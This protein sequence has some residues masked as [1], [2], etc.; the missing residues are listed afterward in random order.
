MD[1]YQILKEY[2]GYDDF[3]QG[4]LKAIDS[5][6]SGTDTVAIMPTGGGKSICFQVPAMMFRGIT[7]VISP[8]ISLMNDQ[9]RA[10]SQCG[11]PAAYINTSLDE[12]VI[13]E[14]I[15]RT[16]AGRYKILYVAPERLLTSG[17]RSLCNTVEVSFVAIDEAHC[18]SQWGQD[19]RPSYLDI[20]EFIASLDKRPV[21]AAFTATATK[22]V[23]QDICSLL[24][25]RSPE[26]IATGFDREN[27][28][29]EV[30]KVKDKL[31]ALKRYLDL[32]SGSSGIVYCSTRKNVD[33]LYY[34]LK[35]ENIPV[36]R[37]HAGLSKNER[38]NNQDSFIQDE[39]P[40]IVATNA[41]GMGIDKSNVSFV[42]H[43][44]MPGDIESYYQEAGRAGRDGSDA[45]CVLLF[46]PSDI[47]V[48]KWFIN[49]AEDNQYL[50]E[51][52]LLQLKKL[53]LEKLQHMVDYC[54][55]ELCL[56]NHILRYFGENPTQRCGNCSFC[57]GNTSSVDV[58]LQAQKIFSCI[59]RVKEKESEQ[60]I[61]DILKGNE[62]EYIT[63][64]GY[65]E[66]SVF[67]IMNDSAQSQIELYIDYFFKRMLLSK[68]EDG[69]LRLENSGKE[70][71]FKGRRI[72]KL[73]ASKKAKDEQIVTLDLRLLTQLKI[74]RKDLANKSGMPAFVIFTDKTLE[75]MARYKPK[76]EKELSLI[77]GVGQ[78]KMEK[79]G[80]YFLEHINKE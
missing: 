48:Q 46:S 38:K 65:N 60:V 49:N 3:R 45:S 28:Y 54:K 79:Y 30:V 34:E 39:K 35:N 20:K 69:A 2:F 66:L 33:E 62:T 19:F 21:V 4:Q 42:I 77:P 25:L 15:S 76:D 22:I 26:E 74:I 63:E 72:R 71:L 57:T 58:T 5:I 23:K 36:T 78:K 70:V 13:A 41:F 68:A 31:T 18:V 75:A 37:Y 9:V 44:N 1:K 16:K 24:G 6:L 43:Y 7:V 53:R 17:F 47:I 51:S 12:R 27:L 10:L 11:I 80:K 29:F 64:K 50:G 67:G 59:R 73:T 52:Q 8:L 55:G 14:V 56:R 32:Y 40:V 61:V